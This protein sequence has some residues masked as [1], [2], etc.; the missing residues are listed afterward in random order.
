MRLGHTSLELVDHDREGRPRACRH[1]AWPAHI[2]EFGRCNYICSCDIWIRM[3]WLTSLQPRLVVMVMLT[4]GTRVAC[5]YIHVYG[6]GVYYTD[7]KYIWVGVVHGYVCDYLA[8]DVT[9]SF[10]ALTILSRINNG[11]MYV[12]ISFILGHSFISFHPNF[13]INKIVDLC[14][15]SAHQPTDKQH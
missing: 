1:M 6:H 3:I 14:Q 2:L 10:H 4:I 13:H 8:T 11:H 15:S 7:I 9:H 12:L 5:E